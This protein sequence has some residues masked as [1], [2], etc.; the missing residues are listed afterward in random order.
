MSFEDVHADTCMHSVAIGVA[1]DIGR[2]IQDLYD[3]QHA[4]N[5]ETDGAM[6]NVVLAALTIVW[7]DAAHTAWNTPAGESA[8]S[9]MRGLK[10][11]HKGRKREMQ[12]AARDFLRRSG[13]WVRRTK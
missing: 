13:W 10:P 3:A 12:R 9:L 1:D 5:Q 11:G 8:I 6:A 2:Y 4:R 7:L